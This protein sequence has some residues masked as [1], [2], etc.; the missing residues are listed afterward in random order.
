MIIDEAKGQV[1]L[2]LLLFTCPRPS[3]LLS[4]CSVSEDL[5]IDDGVPSRGKRQGLLHDLTCCG[6]RFEVQGAGTH[7]QLHLCPGSE[8]RTSLCESGEY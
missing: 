1:S 4:S 8:T 2:V 7:I 5:I 6:G 3:N